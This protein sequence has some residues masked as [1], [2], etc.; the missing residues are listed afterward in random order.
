MVKLIKGAKKKVEQERKKLI[1]DGMKEYMLGNVLEQQRVEIAK[2][3]ADVFI[4]IILF[5]LF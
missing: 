5:L 1:N 4:I 3:F 2:T